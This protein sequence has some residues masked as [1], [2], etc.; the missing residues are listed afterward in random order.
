MCSNNVVHET[1]RQIH[2]NINLS[3]HEYKVLYPSGLSLGKFCDTD[4]IHKVPK[5]GNIEQ[6][7]MRPTVSNLNTATC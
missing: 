2:K 4:K 6:L 3:K 7:R 1:R 5:N